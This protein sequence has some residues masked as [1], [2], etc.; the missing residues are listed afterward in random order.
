MLCH[1]PVTTCD[2]IDVCLS[3]RYLHLNDSSVTAAYFR[4]WPY[5]SL[6]DEELDEPD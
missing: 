4:D 5:Q 3:A 6:L 1:A 2:L